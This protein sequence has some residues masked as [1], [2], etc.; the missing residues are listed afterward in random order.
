MPPPVSDP[1][2]SGRVI[3][4]A[5]R[6]TITRAAVRQRESL[7]AGG[8]RQLTHTQVFQAQAK[9]LEEELFAHVRQYIPASVPFVDL[10]THRE[11]GIV[12][13]SLAAVLALLMAGCLVFSFM[14]IRGQLE[15]RNWIATP[16]VIHSSGAAQF[17]TE[18]PAGRRSPPASK[19]EVPSTFYN[20]HYRYEFN[21]Q[22][23]SSDRVERYWS[24]FLSRSYTRFLAANF[25]RDAQVTAFVNPQRPSEA[26]LRTDLVAQHAMLA[27]LAIP[28]L[29]TIV[30]LCKKALHSVIDSVWKKSLSPIAGGEDGDI[31]YVSLPHRG[32]VHYALIVWVIVLGAI[33]LCFIVTSFIWYLPISPWLLVPL[34]SASVVVAV[35]A[36]FRKR[37]AIR[38]GRK[39]L[40][41]NRSTRSI[42]LPATFGRTERI[43]VP[44]DQIQAVQTADEISTGIGLSRGDE[45][46][47]SGT[48]LSLLTQDTEHILAIR[49]EA[50]LT[51]NL[52]A[53]LAMVLSEVKSSPASK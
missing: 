49:K 4:P 10:S 21:G 27:I 25:P 29:P 28:L 47:Y 20:V 48:R 31:I 12:K 13:L 23:H 41:I 50:V 1:S 33:G 43:T 2:Q 26:V 52:G 5:L 42:T 14:A 39:D 44:I 22:R 40:H 51:D 34:Y 3:P 15:T 36:G 9:E 38:A 8:S 17:T 7:T 32:P 6:A 37:A 53:W 16:A 18:L 46:L 19:Q 45:P 30:L 24:F 35:V 11:F